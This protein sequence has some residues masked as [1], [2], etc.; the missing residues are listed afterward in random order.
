M[1]RRVA[2]EGVT[3]VIIEHTLHAMV[4]LVDRFVVL[5]HGTVLAEGL[6]AEVTRNPAVIEAYLGQGVGRKCLRSTHLRGRLWRPARALRGVSLNAAAGAFVAIVGPNGAGKTTL[7]QERFPARSAP[8]AGRIRF[9]GQDLL[10][11]RPAARPHLGI[12]HVPEGRQVFPSLT[13]RENL[14]MGALR[15][16]G[17]RD[18]KANLERVLT[19]FPILV[20]TQWPACRH[21]IRRAAAD[22]G[23]RAGD[24]VL[25][26]AADAGRA[27]DGSRA[28]DRGLHLFA[29]G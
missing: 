27:V 17:R 28:G 7:V 9:D 18:W 29:F 19:W 12:A 5:D 24:G 8:H 1:V 3:I 15:T 23:D 10:A 16:A 11:M 26:A 21:A 22:A 20:G 6:P 4:R 14:E 25:A 2:A 13:V